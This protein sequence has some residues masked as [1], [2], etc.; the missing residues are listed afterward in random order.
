MDKSQR[1]RLTAI[2]KC[3]NQQYLNSI[4]S[5]DCYSKFEQRF[6]KLTRKVRSL[7]RK[8]Y[9][10]KHSIVELSRIS[11]LIVGFSENMKQREMPAFDFSA[12]KNVLNEYLI[13][14]LDAKRKN[15]YEGQ[16]ASYGETLFVLYLDLFLTATASG[17]VR[18]LQANPEFLVNPKTGSVLEI[19]ALF[20]DFRLAFEFQ[21]EHHYT[22]PKTQQKDLFKLNECRNKKII[23]IPVNISQLNSKSLQV[24]IVNSIKDFFG[25]HDLFRLCCTNMKQLK[26]S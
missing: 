17:A 25:I 9:G 24:L 18:E 23:L 13:N 2:I 7:T 20:E 4:I 12:Y 10:S 22:D 11:R 8:E 6:S 1:N 16:C 5:T 15:N 14:Y 3:S 26:L 21:G 19:D